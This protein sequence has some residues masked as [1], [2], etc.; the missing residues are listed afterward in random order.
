VL[1]PADKPNGQASRSCSPRWR[2]S[3]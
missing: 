2:S 3:T 1:P